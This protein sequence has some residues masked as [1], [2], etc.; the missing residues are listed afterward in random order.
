LKS[1]GRL[2]EAR[3]FEVLTALDAPSALMASRDAAR[4][5]LLVTDVFLP[6]IDGVELAAIIGEVRPE[7][8]VLFISGL[9]ATPAG[10]ALPRTW[11][12]LAKPFTSQDLDACLVRLLGPGGPGSAMRR[13]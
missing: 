9:D 2:F 7:L 1:A 13:E 10:E 4:L 8:P 3:G 5:D 11:A 12:F 6:G